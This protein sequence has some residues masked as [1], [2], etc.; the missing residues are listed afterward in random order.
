LATRITDGLL[1]FGP[2]EICDLF[3]EL[4]QRTYLGAD[5]VWVPSG[6]KHV[7]DDPP[8]GMLHFISDEVESVLQVLDVNKGSGPDGIT[9]TNLKNCAIAF[10]KPLSLKK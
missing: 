8:F 9:P 6:P 2:E 3:A 7:P 4:I 5:H 10:A 1:A